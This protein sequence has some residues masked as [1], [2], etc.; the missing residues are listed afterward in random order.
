M[1]SALALARVI[2]I[3]PKDGY[4]KQLKV[5]VGSGERLNAVHTSF[6][7]TVFIEGKWEFEEDSSYV[8][9]DIVPSTLRADM[10]GQLMFKANTVTPFHCAVCTCLEIE[11]PGEEAYVYPV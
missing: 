1:H 10:E 5:I 9:V 2:W 8:D 4:R 11:V 6:G 7:S 3:S